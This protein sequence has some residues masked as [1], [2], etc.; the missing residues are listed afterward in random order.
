[1]YKSLKK[2][3]EEHCKKLQM[4]S[5]GPTRASRLV[6][7]TRNYTCCMLP[8]TEK[9]RYHQNFT[10]LNSPIHDTSFEAFNKISS[11]FQFDSCQ[12]SNEVTKLYAHNKQTQCTGSLPTY[13]AKTKHINIIVNEQTHLYEERDKVDYR[14]S[15]VYSEKQMYEESPVFHPQAFFLAHLIL[16]QFDPTLQQ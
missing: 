13:P 4:P 10:R 9:L 7:N 16:E 5:T 6:H 11:I 1:M 3:K 2:K 8:T 15:H 12:L 14:P